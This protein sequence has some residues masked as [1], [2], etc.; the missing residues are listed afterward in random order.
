MCGIIRDKILNDTGMDWVPIVLV[1]NK[2]DLGQTGQ[3]TV[4][5][6]EAKAVAAKWGAL[7]VETVC[8]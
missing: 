6:E 5:E 4:S 8:Y 3:R 2:A 1:G 7:F